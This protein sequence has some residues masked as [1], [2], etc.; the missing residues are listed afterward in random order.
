ML[1]KAIKP[2]PIFLQQQRTNQ[3]MK[4]RGLAAMLSP[5]GTLLPGDP[6]WATVHPDRLPEY[7]YLWQGVGTENY[8]D[9]ILIDSLRFDTVIP[10]MT[11]IPKHSDTAQWGFS[12]DL[13]IYEVLFDKPVYVDSDFWIGGSFNS[14]KTAFGTDLAY[15]WVMYILPREIYGCQCL[16]HFAFSEGPRDGLYYIID[17]CLCNWSAFFAITDPKRIV[18][19]H[20]ADSLMGLVSGGG[21]YFDSTFATLYAMPNPGYKFSH[22]EDSSTAN[23]RQLYVL[24]DTSVTAYFEKLDSFYVRLSVN[25]PQWGSVEGEGLHPENHLVTISATPVDDNASFDGWGDGIYENPRNIF[26]T[27]DTSFTAIFSYDSTGLGLST[28][29]D[30][31]LSVSPNP[32]RHT[33]KVRTSADVQG[34]LEIYNAEGQRLQSSSIEDREARLD[35]SRLPSGQYLLRL[36]TREATSSAKFV[37]R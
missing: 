35:V 13:E 28:L 32:V 8:A 31:G 2:P 27:Q 26:L 36:R 17:S 20:S 15:P 5:K 7:L 12:H 29:A 11:R 23:P 30:F 37:K 22:W 34:T 4:V 24:S 25:N 19:G 16:D 21:F 6:H 1:F 3:R 9:L 18:T 10:S 33:L 14:N